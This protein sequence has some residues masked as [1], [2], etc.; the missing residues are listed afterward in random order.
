MT[1]CFHAP[2][3]INCVILASFF[4]VRVFESFLGYGYVPVHPVEVLIA[5]RPFLG[6]AKWW[7]LFS[8]SL[9]AIYPS[10]SFF[11]FPR[12]LRLP[13]FLLSFTFFLPSWPSTRVQTS[14]SSYDDDDG[15]AFAFLKFFLLSTSLP[16]IPVTLVSPSDKGTVCSF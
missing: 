5:R 11:F 1:T 10:H 16:Q 8:G 15:D 12:L 14:V 3:R 2:T 7:I 4:R 6:G 13:L 9:C